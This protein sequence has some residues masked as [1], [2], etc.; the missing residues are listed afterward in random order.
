[1]S[2]KVNSNNI[3]NLTKIALC[4]ALLCV[5]S[6]LVFPLPFTPIVISLHTVVVNLIG[7]ILKPKQA[8]VS[9]LVYLLMG[10][11]GLPVFSAGTAGPGKLLGPT[12]GFYFGFLFATIAISL[13]KGNGNKLWRYILITIAVGLP[14]QHICAI[15]MM[16][17]YNGGNVGAAFL[18]VSLPFVVVDVVKCVTASIV[19]RVLN[20]AMSRN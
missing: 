8:G 16:S 10:F 13:L 7:L 14:I 20:K 15:T 18:T 3:Y 6:Y 9:M 12:G 5:S 1:M 17:I 4:V 19:G 2:T 11:I